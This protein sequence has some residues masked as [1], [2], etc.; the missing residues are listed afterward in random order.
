MERGLA[1]DLKTTWGIEANGVCR[2]TSRTSS[3]EPPSPGFMTTPD[4]ESRTGAAPVS[5]HTYSLTISWAISPRVTALTLLR[6]PLP[7]DQLQEHK[8]RANQPKTKTKPR[9]NPV[10]KETRRIDTSCELRATIKNQRCTMHE[11]CHCHRPSAPA[12][13]RQPEPGGPRG[14]FAGGLDAA[15]DV[16]SS[17]VLRGATLYLPLI[18]SPQSLV[19][20][21]LSCITC[22]GTRREL[23]RACGSV[24]RQCHCS[25]SPS[26][27]PHPTLGLGCWCGGVY[28]EKG[29]GGHRG[30]ASIMRR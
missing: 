2:S 8:P 18:P 28:R 4:S 24:H 7:P 29:E 13:Q 11:Q 20:Y 12:P 27:F 14:A 10:T 17:S 30:W 22:H 5:D 16:H 25:T 15:R 21:H 3:T 26:A 6:P 1:S 23:G 19:M 9:A